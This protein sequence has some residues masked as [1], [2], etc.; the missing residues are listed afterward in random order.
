MSVSVERL[1]PTWKRESKLI[2]QEGTKKNCSSWFAVLNL[3]FVITVRKVIMNTPFVHHRSMF[4]EFQRLRRLSLIR[5]QL[6]MTQG[7]TDKAVL[8]WHILVQKFATTSMLKVVISKF[9]ISS[10][11]VRSV[12]HLI[13]GSPNVSLRN[14]KPQLPH[15]IQSLRKVNKRAW[16]DWICLIPDLPP[17]LSMLTIYKWNCRVIQTQLLFNTCVKACERDL[18]P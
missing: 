3:K 7:L 15:P 11:F 12:N 5:G 9:V 6:S 2:G 17:P 14:Q 8:K 13:M 1:R 4:L 16:H 18:I 10:I